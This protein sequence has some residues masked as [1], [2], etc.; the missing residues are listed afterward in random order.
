MGLSGRTNYRCVRWIENA[1]SAPAGLQQVLATH[2]D[3]LIDM[4][5]MK[6]GFEI[7]REFLCAFYSTTPVPSDRHMPEYPNQSAD[8][9]QLL[10]CPNDMG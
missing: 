1:Q 3:V 10:V 2:S 9:I 4:S 5:V 7:F 6:G 8:V